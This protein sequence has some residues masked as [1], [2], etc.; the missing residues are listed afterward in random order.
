MSKLCLKLGKST[1][2]LCPLVLQ[3]WI[4]MPQMESEQKK[5]DEIREWDRSNR[6]RH[7]QFLKRREEWQESLR[8]VRG[9]HPKL[10]AYLDELSKIFDEQ[11]LSNALSYAQQKKLSV[12]NERLQVIL[13][14]DKY[15]DGQRIESM[16]G[17][18]L[19]KNVLGPI[20]EVPISALRLIAEEV[21]N[22]RFIRPIVLVDENDSYY[23][24]CYGMKKDELLPIEY[25]SW[26]DPVEK[27][28]GEVIKDHLTVGLSSNLSLKESA[29]VLKS[30]GAW[31]FCKYIN[32]YY[33]KNLENSYTIRIPQG[34][35]LNEFFEQIMHDPDV[36]TF[37]VKPAVRLLKKAD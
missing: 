36:K 30:Y 27:E 4:A 7:E 21:E 32:D 6:T 14:T 12:S 35:S 37:A 19:G 25:V 5:M 33:P 17:K 3:V 11:G 9:Y 2:I 22:I 8:T 23:Q 10:H 18:L 28:V 20:I 13:E 24:N 31:I 26:T 29:Q 15:V 34:S 1:L 16:G